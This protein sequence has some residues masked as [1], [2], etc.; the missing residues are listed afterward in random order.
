MVV[1]PIFLL[2]SLL[3]PSPIRRVLRTQMAARDGEMAPVY[4][5]KQREIEKFRKLGK[6]GEIF[7]EF[8][9]KITY[10]TRKYHRTEVRAT[11]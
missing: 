1:V 3:F 11:I 7:F 6:I 4:R 10:Q 9:T 5:I 2:Q 8:Q